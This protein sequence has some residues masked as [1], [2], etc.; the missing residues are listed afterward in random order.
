[1]AKK[2][3]VIFMPPSSTTDMPFHSDPIAVPFLLLNLPSYNARLTSSLSMNSENP[4]HH[5]APP[6]DGQDGL[7][8]HLHPAEDIAA[9]EHAEI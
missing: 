1:M 7:L 4:R 9:L 2:G 5:C 8:L 3:T 6:L